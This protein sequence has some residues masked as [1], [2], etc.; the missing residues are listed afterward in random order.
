MTVNLM[1]WARIDVERNVPI[2]TR[3]RFPLHPS[4]PMERGQIKEQSANTP[5]S[6][7]FARV[8]LGVVER[9]AGKLG[10]D[11]V[12]V[13]KEPRVTPVSIDMG[14]HHCR[15]A[16]ARGVAVTR[17]GRQG[18]ADGVAQT[19][20]GEARAVKVVEVSVP[21]QPLRFRLMIVAPSPV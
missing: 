9:M 8:R 7:T 10:G 12:P 20:T 11:A 5:I 14:M 15:G 21:V 1:I 17:R 19:A 3:I 13:D 16:V 2:S 6:G 18:D 4:L